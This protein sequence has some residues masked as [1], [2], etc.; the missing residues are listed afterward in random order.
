MDFDFSIHS[1]EQMTSRGI[2]N[3]QVIEV[4]KNPDQVIKES[5]VSD[6]EVYQSIFK[7]IQGGNYMI[8]V[9]VNRIKNSKLVVT[10]YK[11]TKVFKYWQNEGNL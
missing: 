5:E 8:R 1:L 7:N 11:T 6:I 4:L 3:S 10:V 9:F 2:T